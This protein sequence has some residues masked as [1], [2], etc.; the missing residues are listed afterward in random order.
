MS[1]PERKSGE[2]VPE[3][4]FTTAEKIRGGLELLRQIAKPART[5]VAGPFAGEF[6]FE[7]MLW[8][9]FV[10]ARA[11]HYERTVVL[12]YPG[13]DELYENCSVVPHDVDLRTA[14]Y[15]F[16]RMSAAETLRRAHEAAERLGLGDYDVFTKM[17]VSTRYHRRFLCPQKL[18]L[19]RQPPRAG[20]PRDV[21]FHFRQ[22]AKE[23]WDTLKNY[24]PGLADEAVRLLRASGL[25]VCCFG[26]PQFSYCPPGCE[27][28]RSEDL[29]ESIAAICSARLV[30]GENSGPMHLA[31]LCG[32]PTLIWAAAP[33]RI[34]YS[35]RWN[36]FDV[37]IFVATDQTHQPDPRLIADRT[38][39]ALAGLE[40]WK[41]AF[42]NA[43][44]PVF[45]AHP[46]VV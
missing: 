2:G 42:A 30:A 35:L 27:D 18:L 10:R 17:H 25:R 41:P 34:A 14:G 28:L 23:G 11:A 1:A 31:N 29:R 21:A 6:G 22:I 39:A 24:T 5:L 19:L 16:G 38:A 7:L 45:A 43:N 36:P 44:G 37:P 12:T 26:H 33:W 4:R 15:G 3:Y 40:R 32:L 46:P 8:Q 9:G 20:G 13:R